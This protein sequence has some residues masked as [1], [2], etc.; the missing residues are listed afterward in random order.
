MRLR[1]PHPKAHDKERRR[2]EAE[3]KAEEAVLHQPTPSAGD[4]GG[5]SQQRSCLGAHRRPTTTQETESQ[6]DA[7]PLPIAD[8]VVSSGRPWHGSAARKGKRV[9]TLQGRTRR[10]STVLMARLRVGDRSG[11]RAVAEPRLAA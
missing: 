7:S 4:A 10:R 8:K 2:S 9:Q 6:G 5:T 1:A 3:P 11:A